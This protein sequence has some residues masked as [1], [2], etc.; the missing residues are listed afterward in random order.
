M[1]VHV[2]AARN[3][4]PLGEH[5]GRAVLVLIVATAAG[6]FTWLIA[7][8]AVYITDFQYL[9]H[10]ARLWT[11]GVD[12]Y[13][14]RPGVT[15]T[16]LWPLWDR[17]FYPLPALMV[18]APLAPLALRLAQVAFVVSA[19]VML[20]WRMSREALWPLLIFA[21]PSFALAAFLGQWSPWLTLAALTPGAGFLLAC[22]PTLGLACLTYR[23]SWR[24]L[25]SAAAVLVL[26]L[27]LM[28][29]W[30][31]E[32]L[33]NLRSVRQHPAPITTPMGGWL[34]ALAALRWRT[35]EGRFLLVM[36]C[37]PQLLFF[38]D[39]LP[40]FLVARTLREA[41]FYTLAGLV[42]GAVLLAPSV[43]HSVDV[44][45]AAP[46]ALLGCYLPALWIVMR[47]PNV[48]PAPAWLEQRVARWPRWLRGAQEAVA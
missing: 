33:D 31:V 12:P 5:A 47:R 7:N 46:Y 21:T 1:G 40:L 41:A 27:I 11:R 45:M 37:V 25:V 44:A 26:S 2:D 8:P 16:L 14:A 28:P 24:A 9:W 34:L 13:A 29:R 38:A 39:Q 4:K 48:G 23:P 6:C 22:K 10:G 19:T 36:A 32:W 30:P 18:V 15:A 42:V 17:L 35:R 20:A 43:T 3:R